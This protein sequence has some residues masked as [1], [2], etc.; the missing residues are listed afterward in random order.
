MVAG[1]KRKSRA[2][3]RWGY[4]QDYLFQD[5][6][7]KIYSDEEIER[8]TNEYKIP[9]EH[10]AEVR[11]RLEG[12]ANVW[13][14]W[15]SITD[16]A[17]KRREMMAALDDIEQRV[18][19]LSEQLETLDD[20][21]AQLFWEPETLVRP[22]VHQQLLKF[23]KGEAYERESPWGHGISFY[24]LP[25]GDTLTA[26]SGR[27]DL[28]EALTVIG[29]YCRHARERIPPD[30]GGSPQSEALRMWVINI[31]SLWTDFLGSRFAYS[32]NRGSAT[33][34]CIDAYQTVDPSCAEAR[35]RTAVRRYIQEEGGTSRN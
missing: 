29:N 1:S 7:I 32:K 18:D 22:F 27:Q 33:A 28:I 17:P 30:K 10:V 19:E 21:T 35:V 6:G 8:L 4:R 11:R 24:E 3:P 20:K 9:E 15:R 14:R 26:S 12:A 13:R 34:F 31:A 16:E 25:N 5:D 2:K 23:K